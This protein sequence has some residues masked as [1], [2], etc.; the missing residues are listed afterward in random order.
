MKPRGLEILGWHKGRDLFAEP[1]AQAGFGAPVPESV[2]LFERSCF[3][4][5]L[6]AFTGTDSIMV[7]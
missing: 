6:A 4:A 7:S 3:R 5:Y 1:L 2:V